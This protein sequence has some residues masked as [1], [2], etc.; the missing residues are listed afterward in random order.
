[1]LELEILY[2]FV[3][4]IYLYSFCRVHTK[5]EEDSYDVRADKEHQ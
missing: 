2:N 3:I 5:E 1:M 4:Y